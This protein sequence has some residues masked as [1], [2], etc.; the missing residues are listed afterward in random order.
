MTQVKAIHCTKKIL[1]VELLRVK[2]I[3]LSKEG[4]CVFTHTL[5][6]GGRS[7]INNTRYFHL[8]EATLKRTILPRHLVRVRR[9]RIKCLIRM[10]V[11]VLM[12][13][14][15]FSD[16]PTKI[17]FFLSFSF[18]LCVVSA[19][20]KP[21]RCGGFSCCRSQALGRSGFRTCGL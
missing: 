5:R 10:K 14:V 17:V 4:R 8:S 19:A 15:Q 20:A 7:I 2:A 13:A 21:S 16:C 3:T 1:S 6:K 11:I 12:F 18:W 9:N